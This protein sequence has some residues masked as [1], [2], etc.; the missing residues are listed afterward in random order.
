MRFESKISVAEFDEL[1]RPKLRLFL[2]VDIVGSTDLK[3]HQST[4]SGPHWVFPFLSFFNTFP[5]LFDGAV[6]EE[7]ARATTAN[8][9]ALEF[10]SLWKALGDELIFVT[11]LRNRHAAAVYIR[12]F[13]LALQ[14]AAYNWTNLRFKGTA[15]LAGFPIGNAEIPI[16]SSRTGMGFAADF[17]GPQIDAGFRL[18]NFAT[19]RKFILSADLVY[20]L[21]RAG[22]HGMD[23]YFDGDEPLKGVM[24]GK[25]YPLIWVDC[26]AQPTGKRKSAQP[27]LNQI[28]DLLQGRAKAKP[29]QLLSYLH[30]WLGEWGGKVSRP[31]ICSDQFDDLRKPEGYEKAWEEWKNQLSA[32]FFVMPKEKVNHKELTKV[33]S[34]IRAF[35]KKSK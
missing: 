14:K 17:V 26:E 15:W 22:R 6:A 30:A 20:L 2:S 29:N 7:S 27:T 8:S 24:H 19:S 32:N 18:K 9:S 34:A 1:V 12:A 10:P 21:A 33:P 35:L 4:S 23:F 3:Y 5:E 28:K 11:E 16:A 25:A 13:R 31:F